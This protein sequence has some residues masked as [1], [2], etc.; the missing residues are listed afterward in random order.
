MRLVTVT[1]FDIYLLTKDLRINCFNRKIYSII[2][3]KL[4]SPHYHRHVLHHCNDELENREFMINHALPYLQKHA[5]RYYLPSAI[6]SISIS[7]KELG[8][9]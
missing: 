6:E 5:S 4:S 3:G 8:L 2:L 9:Q 7:I 1:V